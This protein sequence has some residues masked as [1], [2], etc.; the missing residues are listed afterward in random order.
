MIFIFWTS[1]A[2][3]SSG[4]MQCQSPPRADRVRRQ[5]ARPLS[6]DPRSR[7]FLWIKVKRVHTAGAEEKT[8]QSVGK[9]TRIYILDVRQAGFAFRRLLR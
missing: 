3:A 8:D 5:A 6:A 1:A 7:L 9:F 2:Q 4:P